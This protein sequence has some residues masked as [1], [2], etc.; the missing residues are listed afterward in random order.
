MVDGLSK[1]REVGGGGEGGIRRK[2]ST[3]PLGPGREASVD[4]SLFFLS[5]FG[6]SF[7]ANCLSIYIPGLYMPSSTPI[8]WINMKPF[9]SNMPM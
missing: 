1:G 3:V 9:I 2:R 6:L 5:V 7:L 4:T 8:H